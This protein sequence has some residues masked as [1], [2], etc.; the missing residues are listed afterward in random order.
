M[1][2]F[3]D[4]HLQKLIGPGTTGVPHGNRQCRA[5][6]IFRRSADPARRR[7]KAEPVRPTD[8]PSERITRVRVTE[9]ILGKHVREGLSLHG[10]H[11]GQRNIDLRGKVPLASNHRL[12][13]SPVPRRTIR[14]RHAINRDAPLGRFNLQ[15]VAGV[16][17]EIEAVGPVLQADISWEKVEE[18]DA[19]C[20]VDDAILAV[21]PPITHRAGTVEDVIA[22][23]AIEQVRPLT[24]I[25]RTAAVEGIITV[26]AINLIVSEGA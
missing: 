21:T 9:R 23:A 16:D 3:P 20:P 12:D 8:R 4:P 22:G 5:A 14:E 1:I 26:V 15:P 11:R 7:V 17:I 6:D 24:T 19:V 13:R 25:D 10:K 2:G 18:I